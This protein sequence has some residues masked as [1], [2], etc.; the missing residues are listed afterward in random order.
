MN[1]WIIMSMVLASFCIYKSG[2]QG[3]FENCCLSYAH[4]IHKHA[5]YKH[6]K[7]YRIQE[8]NESCNRKAVIFMMPRKDRVVCGNPTEG[9]VQAL[10]KHIVKKTHHSR[11]MRNRKNIH[12]NQ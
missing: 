11:N 8:I 7:S 10:M 2:G 6:A 12:Q 3:H 5:V 4:N 1:T 9:W